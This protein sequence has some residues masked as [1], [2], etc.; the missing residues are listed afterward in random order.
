MYKNEINFS[1]VGEIESIYSVHYYYSERLSDISLP[2]KT[3][4]EVIEVE[5]KSGL[6]L[7]YTV[8]RL[9]H[10][11]DVK[12][13]VAKPIRLYE[14]IEQR[15]K[16]LPKEQW[17]LIAIVLLKNLLNYVPKSYRTLVCEETEPHKYSIEETEF[18][19]NVLKE[20]ANEVSA[21]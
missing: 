18:I 15:K 21:H 19:A 10:P 20:Q 11:A 9:I 5:Y 14:Y 2:I 13:Y 8:E 7:N 3:S 6:V 12:D 4:A 16:E 17:Y 1:P